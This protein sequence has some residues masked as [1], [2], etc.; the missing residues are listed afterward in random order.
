[1]FEKLTN[2]EQL[3][4]GKILK[5]DATH[6]DELVKNPNVNLDDISN[7]YKKMGIKMIDEESWFQCQQLSKINREKYEECS[8]CCLFVPKKLLTN[9]ECTYKYHH[10]K[11]DTTHYRL[12]PVCL[13]VSA[14]NKNYA[15][16]CANGMTGDSKGLIMNRVS[17]ETGTTTNWVVVHPDLPT[18]EH[19]G[20]ICGCEYKRCEY[21]DIDVRFCMNNC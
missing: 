18:R 19:A 2:V 7:F 20:S 13:Y 4:L 3:N 21:C 8:T 5:W 9:V 6:L 10:H 16:A 12:C 17:F 15:N 14:H 11:L 1:M